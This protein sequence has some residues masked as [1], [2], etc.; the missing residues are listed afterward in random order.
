MEDIVQRAA[1]FARK[2]HATQARKYTGEPYF[3][4]LHEVAMILYRHG[5][6]DEVLAA[7]YLHDVI[8]DQPVSREMV[9]EYFGPVVARLVW[10]VTDQSKPSDG[11]RVARKEI[12]R[13]WLSKASPAAQSIKLA[14]LISNGKDITD[15]DPKFAKVFLGEKALLLDVLTS[16]DSWL[17][18]E[19][20]FALIDCQEKLV[21]DNL[22]NKP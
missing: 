5:F 13:Q 9:E 6:R 10:E 15:G 8:E 20:K 11:N 7:A 14:D 16:G 22:S 2:A 1:N 17:F 3:N 12:D 19:A 21:Q 18:T 4:H